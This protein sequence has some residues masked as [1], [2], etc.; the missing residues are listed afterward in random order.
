MR[1]SCLKNSIKKKKIIYEYY[2][3][4]NVRKN[5]LIV[6]NRKKKFSNYF[7]IKTKETFY[8]KYQIDGIYTKKGTYFP[9]KFNKHTIDM[10]NSQDIINRNLILETI[11][12]KYINK[13]KK[14]RENKKSL[15]TFNYFR[16]I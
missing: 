7:A 15:E 16:I 12:N 3:Y 1:K 4:Y 6:L 11:Y 2:L 10:L 5:C 13:I 14:L 8:F 9:I